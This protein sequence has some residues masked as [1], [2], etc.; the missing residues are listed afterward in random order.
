VTETRIRWEDEP[1]ASGDV[2]LIASTGYIGTVKEPAFKIYT[3]DELHD[4]WLLS[5]RLLAGG[6]FF[7]ADDRAILKAEAER[8]LR[9]FVSSLG[10]VFPAVHTEGPKRMTG[11]KLVR[12][13]SCGKPW[14]CPEDLTLPAPGPATGME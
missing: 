5:V 4:N 8:W 7:R 2:Y 9:V 1:P 3:P 14:P 10:A 11:R 6:Q 12:T 13:C